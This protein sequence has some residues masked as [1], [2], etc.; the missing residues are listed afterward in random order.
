MLKIFSKNSNNRTVNLL[1][2][3][4]YPRENRMMLKVLSRDGSNYCKLITLYATI[5]ASNNII[6]YYTCI[7]SDAKY[8]R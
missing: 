7:L 5:S 3:Y 8:L 6:A 2:E 1:S 4:G